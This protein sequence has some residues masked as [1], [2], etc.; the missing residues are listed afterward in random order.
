MN[1]LSTNFANLAF[2]VLVSMMAISTIICLIIWLTSLDRKTSATD[3]FA[4]WKLAIVV[5]IIAP[6][7]T[8]LLPTYP[9]GWFANQSA[10]S[11]DVVTNAKSEQTAISGGTVDP[12]R[13]NSDAMPVRPDSMSNTR[14]EIPT[15]IESKNRKHEAASG[16]DAALL[17]SSFTS[18]L[19]QLPWNVILLAVWLGVMLV[20]LLRF[21]LS[22]LQIRIIERNAAPFPND[23]VASDH[24]I[25]ASDRLQIPV[26]TGV[27]NPKII[28]PGNATDWEPETLR[29]IVRHESAHIQRR[30]VAWQLLTAMVRCLYWPQP[31]L[32][33]TDK[34]MQLVRERACDDQVLQQGETPSAYAS[35]LLQIAVELSGRHQNLVGAIPVAC[36]PIEKRL[37]AIL[38]PLTPRAPGNQ[39]S[40]KTIALAVCL[41]ALSCCCLRPFEKLHETISPIANEKLAISMGDQEK[42][43]KEVRDPQHEEEVPLPGTITGIV[44]DH[45]LVPVAGAEVKFWFFGKQKNSSSHLDVKTRIELVGTTDESGRYTIDSSG[46]SFNGGYSGHGVVNAKGFPQASVPYIPNAKDEALDMPNTV[47]HQKRRITGRIVSMEGD[48]VP[49][50][51]IIRLV[52]NTGESV[53]KD[54]PCPYFFSPSISC[55]ATGRFETWIPSN[56]PVAMSIR[57]D[58]HS[59][60]QML[61]PGDEEELGEIELLK[62]SRLSGQVLDKDGK[63]VAGVIVNIRST[64]SLGNGYRLLSDSVKSDKVGNYQLPP[65]RGPCVVWVSESGNFRDGSILKGDRKP[66]I[67]KPQIVELAGTRATNLNLIESKTVSVR[68]TI[69]WDDGTPAANIDVTCSI[70]SELVRTRSVNRTFTD[71][72]GRYEL[73]IPQY[74][75]DGK[76]QISITGDTHPVDGRYYEPHTLN[77]LDVMKKGKSSMTLKATLTDLEGADWELRSTVTRRKLPPLEISVPTPAH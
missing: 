3:R 73:A 61:V 64:E 13:A 48:S 70:Y 21:A 26:T 51:C 7:G 68:G 16:A 5:L 37:A 53:E 2:D 52:G 40:R 67:I 11:N 49:K 71:E 10:A 55:D 33:M 63:P 45:S 14:T 34:Q 39:T 58:D 76:V 62:G 9:L 47:F 19:K 31:L 22:V 28:L 65:F 57:S 18:R 1:L 50:N 23:E 20:L 15:T 17:A 43:E 54:F 32:W 6:V 77:D 8:L 36:K 41:L 25:F 72:E 69:R 56:M 66:P 59:G 42:E 44:V 29:M 30:D 24:P 60:H 38:E 46:H 74:A 12:I 75:E 35:V 4:A 27:R